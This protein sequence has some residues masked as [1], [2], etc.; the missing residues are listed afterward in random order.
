MQPALSGT[1]QLSDSLKAYLNNKSRLQPIIGLGSIGECVNVAS[2][3][4]ET[5]YLCEACA[6]RL[7]TADIRNH[8][9]GSHHRFNYIKA[10]HPHLVSEWQQSPDLSKLAWPLMELAKTLEGKEGPGEVQLFEVPDAV[11]RRITTERESDAFL[12]TALRDERGRSG[13]CSDA[14]PL[15][16]PFESHRI[17]LHARSQPG[18]SGVLDSAG[19]KPHEMSAPPIPANRAPVCSQY[20]PTSHHTSPEPSVLSDDD[21]FSGDVS[22]GKPLIGLVR[23]DELRSENGGSYGFLCHCCRIRSNEKDIFDHLTSYSHLSNY[24]METQPDLLNLMNEDTEANFQLLRSLADQVEQHEGR[25][26]LKIINVPESFCR[27]ITGKSY[28]WCLS[29]LSSGWVNTNIQK[30][31]EAVKGVTKPLMPTE[32]PAVTS[33]RAKREKP[34]KKRKKKTDPM[35]NVSF[36]LRKG[37]MLLERTSFRRDNLLELAPSLLPERDQISLPAGGGLKCDPAPFES[38][39]AKGPSGLQTSQLEQDLCDGD[40]DPG[41]Y[42]PETHI[43]VT[44][45]QDAEGI[46]SVHFKQPSRETETED[47]MVYGGR[48]HGPQRLYEDWQNE[49]V[50]AQSEGLFP[51]V[52]HSGDWCPYKS[53]YRQEDDSDRW[54]SSASAQTSVDESRQMEGNLNS[55]AVQRHRRQNR[56]M[57]WDSAGSGSGSVWGRPDLPGEVAS[58]I[59]A[60]Q[61]NVR[62]H[63][64]H[65]GSVPPQPGVRFHETEARFNCYYTEPQHRMTRSTADRVSQRS[66]GQNTGPGTNRKRYGAYP[67]SRGEGVGGT[68]MQPNAF[69]RPGQAAYY[70]AGSD[71][72]YRTGL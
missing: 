22:G 35:F 18:A 63:S 38:C 70:G 47:H 61:T 37:A 66:N 44:V 53:Y 10:C 65:G 28:H 16:Y 5:L 20:T 57:A 23:V 25:G 54:F 24:L 32:I 52:S 13:S 34:R 27:Q 50:P 7:A 3:N 42:V 30:R 62:T 60:A 64:A 14:M 31:R 29:M 6:C 59:E 21:N 49:D 43:K 2:G 11:Y 8:I 1:S 48:W 36:P 68:S 17:V 4:R 33:K 58:F 41:D 71:I 15:H 72:Y 55:C 51:A 39:D 9:L 12:M 19:M 69:I 46:D 56:Q 45:F 26:E 67:V 40:V